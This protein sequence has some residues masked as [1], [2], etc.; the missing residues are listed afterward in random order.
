MK[1]F[2]SFSPLYSL[3]DDNRNKVLA[4]PGEKIKK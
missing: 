1:M 4:F 3:T 2:I